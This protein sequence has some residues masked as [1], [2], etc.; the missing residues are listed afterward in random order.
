MQAIINQVYPLSEEDYA[1]LWQITRPVQFERGNL[2]L[3]EGQ[4]CQELY[5]VETGL[6]GLAKV[7]KER[8]YYQDFFFEG[9]FATN[10][11]SLTNNAPSEADLVAIESVEA[12]YIGKTALLE[13]YEASN[14][15]KEFGRRLL[16][17]L[18]AKQTKLAFVRSSFTAKEKYAYLLEHFPHYVQR[19]PLQLLASYLGMTRETL[20][21]IRSTIQKG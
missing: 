11:I 7:F 6:I 14:A 3:R 16:Q 12:R 4:T 21:R 1:A 5:F 18:L 13:L 19:V 8:S 10:I 17:Q 15:F 2:I 20:S 9:S